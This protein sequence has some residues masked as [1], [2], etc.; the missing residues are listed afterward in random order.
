MNFFISLAIAVFLFLSLLSTIVTFNLNKLLLTC[1]CL[2]FNGILCLYE[3]HMKKLGE[4]FRRNFGFLF[5]YIGRSIF[6][7]LLSWLGL[8]MHSIGTI[9]MALGSM[10]SLLAIVVFGVAALN[11]IVTVLHPSFRRGDISLLDDPS[12]SYTSGDSVGAVVV[13]HVQEIK[14]YMVSNPELAQ[15][16]LQGAVT[17]SAK[18][19]SV[20]SIL[21][22][23]MSRGAFALPKYYGTNITFDRE[24]KSALEYLM[25]VRH[26]AESMPD[27]E[28]ADLNV[29][30]SIVFVTNRS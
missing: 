13:T 25:S 9:M 2:L 4:R 19:Y 8:L 23:S 15:K 21:L 10:Y 12:V 14:N 30:R 16:V 1:Y 20:C 6:V 26:E 11:V 27:Y 24:P 5:T 18:A 3:L 17:L 7:F 22:L 29:R 28:T